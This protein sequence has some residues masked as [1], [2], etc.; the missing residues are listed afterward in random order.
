MEAEA[1]EEAMAIIKEW[2][3]HGDRGG[4]KREVPEIFSRKN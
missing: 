2:N 4:E 3:C 1:S